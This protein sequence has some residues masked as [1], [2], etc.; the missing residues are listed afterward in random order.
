M[1]FVACIIPDKKKEG[2]SKSTESGQ[3]E[4]AYHPEKAATLI[5]LRVISNT[6]CVR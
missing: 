3:V 1:G 2:W 5:I 4:I 6:R